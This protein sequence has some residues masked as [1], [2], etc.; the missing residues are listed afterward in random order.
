MRLGLIGLGRIGAF[1][2]ETLKAC[3]AGLGPEPLPDEV[4]GGGAGSAVVDADVGDPLA[5]RQ[6][7]DQRHHRNPSLRRLHDD[8]DQEGPTTES[9][10]GS[11]ALEVRDRAAYLLD[12][13]G[14]H[15]AP[16][17]EDAVD[18]GLAQ[19]GLR[20]DLTNAERMPHEAES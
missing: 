8:V 16:L 11:L 17:V 1:H 10:L 14:P 15:A 20:G 9:K 18:R 19:T 5:R 13:A 3:V 2:A 7:G 6:I 4:G 12:R